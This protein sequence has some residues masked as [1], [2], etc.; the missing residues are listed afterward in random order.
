MA[1]TLIHKRSA[2]A[3]KVPLPGDLV[4]GELAINT[5]D[6]EVFLK[7]GDGSVI[8]VGNLADTAVKLQTP[9]LISVAQDATGSASFDGS[10]DVT[11]N[12][13]LAS[14]G[15]GAGTYTKLTV[16]AKGIVTSATTLVAGDIP[17]LTS[18][19]I[20][21]F[22][23]QVRTS[24]L[25][26]MAVP[27]AD[28]SLNSRKIVNLATPTAANDAVNKAYVDSLV[29]G[30]APKQSVHVATTANLAAL[31]GLLTV[32]GV[33]LVAGDRVLVKNQTAAA[34]NGIYVAASGAWT[35]ALDAD[36]WND[37]VSAFTFVE[38]GT[39]QAD[40]GWTCTAN[41]GGT[42]GTT[43]MD[44]VQFTG[45]GSITDGAGLSKT[46]NVLD[47]NTGVGLTIT[48]DAV[49]LTGQALA[50]HNLGT[51]GFFVRTAAAT[52]VARSIAVTGSGISVSNGDGVA[53]NPTLSLTT[54]LS[55]IGGLT[56]AAD[57]F[58]YWTSGSA[59][60]LGTI[61]AAG[62]ALIDDADTTAQRTTLGL[63][64]MATQNANAVNIT[65]GTI[66]G[67]TIDGG[68]Y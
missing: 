16:N 58:P 52:V 25:D 65:G 35:R 5:T 43:A 31:S 60:A 17:T 47:V 44:W 66:D 10:A 18:A 8:R 12:L 54:A 51:N 68:A 23:S 19:K 39:T 2:V 29:Q 37:I 64:T 30:L 27:T 21:D 41:A 45:A 7:K 6:G 22:D 62:R 20:S 40:T 13:T 56:P 14:S 28:V 33:L 59:A 49:A 53:G 26:Q 9:R 57:R 11:I 38:E 4:L 67:I 36:S 61:T 34:A 48:S 24:R 1:S 55:T 3:S 15:V 32:D 63:G 42:L 50:L 46:G